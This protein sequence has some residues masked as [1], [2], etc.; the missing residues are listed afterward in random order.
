L[1]VVVAATYDLSTPDSPADFSGLEHIEPDVTEEEVKALFGMH[2]QVWGYKTWS[3][4]EGTLIELAKFG[5]GNFYHI[6]VIMV[7]IQMLGGMRKSAGRQ[8]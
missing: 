5:D 6:G 4:F 2:A 3:K 1:F 8:I 7:G